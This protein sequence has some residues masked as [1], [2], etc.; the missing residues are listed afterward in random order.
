MKNVILLTFLFAVPL[1]SGAGETQLQEFINIALKNNHDVNIASLQLKGARSQ[2][3]GSYSGFLPTVNLSV[4]KGLSQS[5]IPDLYSSR[6]SVS[7]T[8]FDGARSWYANRN[9]ENQINVSAINLQSKEEQVIYAVKF[10]FYSYLKSR[11]LTDVAKLALE[12][13]ISQLELVQQQ[14]DLYAVSETDL[15]KAKVHKGQ[16]EAQIIQ[17]LQGERIAMNSLNIAIGATPGNPLAIKS[18][19]VQLQSIPSFD[20]AKSALFSRNA[21]LQIAR[22]QEEG[23]K[24]ALKTQTGIFYPTVS[25]SSSYSTEKTDFGDLFDGYI[26]AGPTTGLNISFPIFTGLSRASRYH[27]LK[28]AMLASSVIVDQTEDN[29]LSDLDN[30]ITQIDTYHQ[31]IPINEEIILSAEM[32]FRLAEEKYDLGA[33]DILELLNAQVSLIQAKSDLVR[34][35]YDAK[36]S[37]SK[38]EVLMG[39][40]TPY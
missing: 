24:I 18:M 11:E 32:D 31:L 2:Q 26:S 1:F 3:K 30:V 25:I 23:S 36:V 14:F 10:A 40:V 22:Y 15:L 33:S 37:E 13:A 20:E 29:L 39:T 19:N 28:Y 17:S 6:V 4:D 21:Q 27:N 7:E 38:L 35:K 16:A 5:T 8:I 34:L 9:I 12:L